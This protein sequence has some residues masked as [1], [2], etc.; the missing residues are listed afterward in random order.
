VEAGIFVFQQDSASDMLQ[1][2]SLGHIPGLGMQFSCR[3]L[4]SP[5]GSTLASMSP[6]RASG[7]IWLL[8]YKRDFYM[9]ECPCF[10]CRSTCAWS[11]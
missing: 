5:W 9:L 6:I 8:M 7:S 2:S 10:F 11:C 4:A 3:T 1:V